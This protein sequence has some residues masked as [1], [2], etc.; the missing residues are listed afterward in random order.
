MSLTILIDNKEDFNLL[1]AAKQFADDVTVTG[2]FIYPDLQKSDIF[3]FDNIGDGIFS[4]T[5]IHNRKTD[6]YVEKYGMVI[7]ENGVVMKFEIIQ[8]QN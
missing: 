1:Y 8:I 6:S 4:A 3:S 2:Y 5:V 7:K